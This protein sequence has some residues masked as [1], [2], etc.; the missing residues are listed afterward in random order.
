MMHP[1]LTSLKE[2]SEAAG[3]ALPLLEKYADC[4]IKNSPDNRWFIYGSKFG[5][6]T[7]PGPIE[8]RP[9]VCLMNIHRA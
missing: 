9:S 6:Y 8:M 3:Q 2:L 7:A 5:I 1:L 4:S